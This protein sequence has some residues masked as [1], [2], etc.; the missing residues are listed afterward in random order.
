MR[1]ASCDHFELWLGGHSWD[2]AGDYAAVNYA[3]RHACSLLSAITDD[4]DVALWWFD[5][6]HFSWV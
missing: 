6:R 3:Q 2:H 4:Y 5:W 1:I